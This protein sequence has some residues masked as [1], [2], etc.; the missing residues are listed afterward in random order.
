MSTKV[1]PFCAIVAGSGPG[2]VR[3]RTSQ[4][5]VIDP[6]GPHAPG[7]VLVIPTVHVADLTENLAVTCATLEVAAT[8]AAGMSDVNVLTS[9][10]KKATQSVFHLHWHVVPRGAYDHLPPRWPWLSWAHE[11]A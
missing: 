7:H 6:I 4:A 5:L 11:Q 1:C 2:T 9:K 3:M 10:G 8:W